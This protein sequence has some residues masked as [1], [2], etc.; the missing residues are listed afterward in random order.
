[1]FEEENIVSNQEIPASENKEENYEQ[2][3]TQALDKQK[4]YYLRIVADCE[5]RMKRSRQDAMHS[6]NAALENIA[7]DLLP[8]VSDIKNAAII[9]DEKTKSGLALM[10]RN[11]KNILKKYGIEEI[12]A[13]IGQEF[14]PNLHH[15]ISVEE[16]EGTPEGKIT[17]IIQPGY[18]LNGNV[19]SATMVIVSK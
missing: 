11:L 15:A 5:D 3:L 16:K 14:D 8:F 4:E 12:L 17:Q 2:K 7:R 6:I 1:M 19:I 10:E 18:K 13:E 9:S